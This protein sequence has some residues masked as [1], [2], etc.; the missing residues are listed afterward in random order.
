MLLMKNGKYSE[1][2]QSLRAVGNDSFNEFFNLAS[3]RCA[4]EIRL[5]YSA[6]FKVI[7]FIY[8]AE[9]PEVGIKAAKMK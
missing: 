7:I 5:S 8:A 3:Y 4:Y 9:L 2:S 1:K 6:S